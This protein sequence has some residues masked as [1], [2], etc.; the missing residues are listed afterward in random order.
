MRFLKNIFGGIKR[1]EPSQTEATGA[2]PPPPEP[3]PQ[4]IRISELTPYELK[5]RLDNGDELVV[6]DMRQAWEYEAGH[7]PGAKHMFI[8]EIPTRYNELPQNT[9]VVFQCWHGNTS[10]DAAGFLIHNG[11]DDSRVFSLSGGISGW[12]STFGPTG[13]VKD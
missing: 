1:K 3:E 6:V 5:A 13:L 8:Q 12:T 7:I 10:L 2:A 11:W 9:T 4:P